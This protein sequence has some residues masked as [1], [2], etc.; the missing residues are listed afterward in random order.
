LSK[1]IDEEDKWTLK[2]I[3]ALGITY[4]KKTSKSTKAITKDQQ[5][6]AT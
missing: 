4:D 6:I 1:F 3:I 5:N 2:N